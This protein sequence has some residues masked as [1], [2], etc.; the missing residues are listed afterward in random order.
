MDIQRIDNYTDTRFSNTVLE[1]HGAYLID[2][3]PYEI[4]ITG[5]SEATVRGKNP[6][7]YAELIEEFRF[8]TPHI[9]RFF[10]D[11][12]S[13]LAEY[14]VPEIIEVKPDQIQPSQFFVDEEKLAAI[15]TFIHRP[16]D[17]VI[18][19]LPWNG[20]F[21]SLDGHTRLYAAVQDGF[22]FVKAVIS[23]T[24]DWVWTF[25]N[26]ARARLIFKPGDMELLEHEEYMLRWDRYCDEIFGREGEALS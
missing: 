24:D 7:A 16:E 4:E 9:V 11:T 12:G 2:G 20:R 1:Q 14:P 15:R 19:V 25:V 26:E 22:P 17:V 23:E 3:D 6:A 8:H 10:D 21:I 5:P 13:P 18:Q